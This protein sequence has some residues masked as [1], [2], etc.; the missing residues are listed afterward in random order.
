ML[1]KSKRTSVG[2]SLGTLILGLET[3]G[4]SGGQANELVSL[5]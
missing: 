5:V 4:V 3:T 1:Y 2:Y